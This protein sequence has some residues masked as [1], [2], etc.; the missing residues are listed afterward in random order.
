MGQDPPV[1]FNLT[2]S[3]LFL[4][5][6]CSISYNYQGSRFSRS[7]NRRNLLTLPPSFLPF[8]KLMQHLRNESWA[9]QCQDRATTQAL[10]NASPQIP[11][12]HNVHYDAKQKEF[13]VGGPPSSP[14]ANAESV[15]RLGMV[16]ILSGTRIPGRRC[17]Q[18]RKVEPLFEGGGPRSL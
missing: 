6:R 15:Y 12:G 4:F 18:R 1:L 16:S 8:T 11:R 10:A 5:W 13:S 9:T 17:R 3:D 14:I 7:Q 2:L